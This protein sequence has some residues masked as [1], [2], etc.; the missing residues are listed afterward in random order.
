METGKYARGQLCTCTSR[1]SSSSL[2]S[3]SLA[4]LP[5]HAVNPD[6]QSVLALSFLLAFASA[7]L[8]V[9]RLLRLRIDPP[10]FSATS[11]ASPAGQSLFSP[12][13]PSAAAAFV[14]L[15]VAH[16]VAW[17]VAAVPPPPFGVAPFAAPSFYY[18]PTCC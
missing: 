17:D 5:S 4:S 6:E 12:V 16:P 13:F 1:L 15:L 14:L 8:A 2:S 18:C 9:C 10:P 7:F 11:S 3:A